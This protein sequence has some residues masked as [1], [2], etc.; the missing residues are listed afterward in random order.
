MQTFLPYPSF[1]RSAACLDY[2]RL[3]KQRLECYQILLA[4]LGGGGSWYNH[5]ATKMW[6][7]TPD[8]L[9][10]YMSTIVWEWEDR[11]YI[12]NMWVPYRRD[13][14]LSPRIDVQSKMHQ[15][16][17]R[18]FVDGVKLPAWLGQPDFHASHRSNLLRKDPDH[19]RK[20]GWKEPTDMEYVW[21]R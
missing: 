12:S 5:P 9:G 21:P 6:R 17:W 18:S 13:L 8:A 20:F 1:S 14:S 19:Y 10:L 11:G 2:R 7:D 16:E 4:N 15:R 3:G